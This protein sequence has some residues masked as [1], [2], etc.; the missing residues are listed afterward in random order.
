MSQVLDTNAVLYLLHGAVGGV[1]GGEDLAISFISEVELLGWR[2]IT[3]AD[4]RAILDLIAS[5][6]VVP[7]DDAIRGESIRLRRT[8]RLKTPDAIIATTALCTGSTLVTN[9]QRLLAIAEVPTL[10]FSP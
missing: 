10:R 1:P 8:Y 9:D 2:G 3:P 6:D 5:M 4:E 7:F